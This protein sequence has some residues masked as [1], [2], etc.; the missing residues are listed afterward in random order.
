MFQ[1]SADR[2]GMCDSDYVGYAARHLHQGTVEP[3]F[4]EVAGDR[5]D[6]FVKS[7]VSYIENLDITNLRGNDQ[8]KTIEFMF[9]GINMFWARLRLILA[10]A[11]RRG[12]K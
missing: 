2:Y 6:L 4:N 9:A 1:F 12:L 3:R 7:R 5:P 10:R 11:V 8:N